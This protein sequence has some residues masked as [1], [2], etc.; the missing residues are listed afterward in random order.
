MNIPAG[1]Y[2]NSFPTGSNYICDPPVLDTDIDVMYWVKDLYETDKYLL[3]NGWTLCGNEEYNNT[4]WKAYRNGKYNAIVT[5]V[6]EHYIKFYA[7]TEL[8]K[9]MNLLD[10]EER[11][12]LFNIICENKYGNRSNQQT[13]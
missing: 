8:A 13:I 11:I 12:E 5:P 9:K 2:Y 6:Y 10:K 1:L 7:A 3:K 4:G